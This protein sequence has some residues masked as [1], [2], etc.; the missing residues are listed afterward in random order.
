MFS[1][2]VGQSSTVISFI[3]HGTPMVHP[4]MNNSPSTFA[5]NTIFG[6]FSF[7][8]NC[9]SHANGQFL[10]YKCW[11]SRLPRYAGNPRNSLIEIGIQNLHHLHKAN[12]SKQIYVWFALGNSEMRLGLSFGKFEKLIDLIGACTKR[13]YTKCFNLFMMVM[14]PCLSVVF[15]GSISNTPFPNRLDPMCMRCLRHSESSLKAFFVINAVDPD[16]KSFEMLGCSNEVTICVVLAE[17][18]LVFLI[19]VVLIKPNPPISHRT[20]AIRTASMSSSRLSSCLFLVAVYLK[21]NCTHKI[22]IF[23]YLERKE[24]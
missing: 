15:L 19:S 23:I 8:S 21:E 12:K 1:T 13:K 4:K 2:I 24:K 20:I 7:P 11:H 6:F 18:A 17:S 22:D 14:A 16:V 10:H 9:P 5:L 3:D